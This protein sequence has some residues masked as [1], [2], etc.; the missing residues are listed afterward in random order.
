M[1]ASGKSCQF[2]ATESCGC[3]SI[4]AYIRGTSEQQECMNIHAVTVVL[5]NNPYV[6]ADPT[7]V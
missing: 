2:I 5:C 4:I 3:I 6:A 7:G 1:L